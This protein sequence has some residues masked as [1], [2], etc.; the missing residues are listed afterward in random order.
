ML[1]QL[2][3]GPPVV[4]RPSA[5]GSVVHVLSIGSPA[6]S[7]STHLDEHVV[8]VLLE[9]VRHL[10]RQRP[11]VPPAGSSVLVQPL[12]RRVVRA[13][14]RRTCVPLNGSNG[15]APGRS[16]LPMLR[17]SANVGKRAGS[18]IVLVTGN[19]AE[20][21]WLPAPVPSKLQVS[22]PSGPTSVPSAS[23]LP[24]LVVDCPPADVHVRP[25]V[26]LEEVVVVRDAAVGRSP[27]RPC[28]TPASSPRAPLAALGRLGEPVV[29]DL[30][31]LGPLPPGVLAGEEQ[32]AALVHV[33][34]RVDLLVEVEARG[35]GAAGLAR[36]PGDVV[37]ARVPDDRL[38]VAEH[39]QPVGR[40]RVVR[41]DVVDVVAD[42][43]LVERVRCSTR[44]TSGRSG[45]AS[46]VGPV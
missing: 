24:V 12:V 37:V 1:G 35:A 4:A 7:S 3:A 38:V 18:R 10:E 23:R 29:A 25:Q 28:R 15:A 33:V 45:P 16:Q 44:G 36:P 34:A 32:L 6:P 22:P 11:A 9:V 30:V 41:V 19:V 13:R 21:A 42:V 43:R 20:L 40:R 17:E 31:A 26:V 39:A 14:R 27:G 2:E 8:V 5:S 46:G